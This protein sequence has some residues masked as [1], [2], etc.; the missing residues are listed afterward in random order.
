M[1][2]LQHDFLPLN[3]GTHVHLRLRIPLF[4]HIVELLVVLRIDELYYQFLTEV[5]SDHYSESLQEELN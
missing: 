4:D 3:I 2:T 1:Y 5:K